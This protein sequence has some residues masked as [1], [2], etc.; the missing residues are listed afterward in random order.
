MPKYIVKII[1]VK[2]EF[3]L[4][5]CLF[6][7]QNPTVTVQNGTT[8]R[9]IMS[10]VVDTMLCLMSRYLKNLKLDCLQILSKSTSYCFC[11]LWYKY[12][13]N[14]I[15]L[16]IVARLCKFQ[17]IWIVAFISFFCKNFTVQ[18]HEFEK[19]QRGMMSG[20][21]YRGDSFLILPEIWFK[22]LRKHANNIFY[23]DIVS[24]NYNVIII[25]KIIAILYCILL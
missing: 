10:Y 1:V 9:E 2:F 11:I 8:C 12:F 14:A 16:R 6:L 13:K 3:F 22:K 23:E 24:N 20:D 19:Y 17:A 18:F 15:I 21:M 5:D 7:V 4:E 25:H